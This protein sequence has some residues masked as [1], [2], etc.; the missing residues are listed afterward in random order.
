VEYSRHVSKYAGLIGTIR[1]IADLAKSP[2]DLPRTFVGAT[3]YQKRRDSITDELG[4]AIS[5][6]GEALVALIAAFEGAISKH[7]G[8]LFRYRDA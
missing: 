7:T 3:D 4:S 2:L 5:G 6:F 8:V 1:A